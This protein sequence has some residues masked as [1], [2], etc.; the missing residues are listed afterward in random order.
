MG[1]P[2]LIEL[3]RS[4]SRDHLDELGRAVLAI[5]RGEGLGAIDAAFRA[6]H[7]LKGMSAAMD[8][9]VVAELAHGLEHT[10]ESLRAG[11]VRADP[12][13]VDT[14][15]RAVDE[16]ERV[17]EAA[18]SGLAERSG[19]DGGDESFPAGE[20]KP[21]VP[22]GASPPGRVVRIPEARIDGLLERTGDLLVARE[23]IIARARASRDER[24]R[25]LAQEFA[26]SIEELRDDALRLRLAPIG[27]I[28]DRIARVVRDTARALDKRVRLHLA[29]VDVEID[30]A[31]LGDVQDLLTHLLRNA[32]DHGIETIAGREAAGKPAEG[33]VRVTVTQQRDSV[34]L[35][36]EDDGRGIDRELV[37][38]RAIAAGIWRSTPGVPIGDEDLLRLLVHPGFTTAH[39]VTEV[40]GRGVG[41]DHVATRSREVGGDLRIASRP[42]RGSRFTLVL[43]R[44]LSQ[45]KVLLAGS[46]GQI[47]G[48]PAGALR[49]IEDEGQLAPGVPEAQDGERERP[50]IEVVDLGG[51]L[52]TA[53]GETPGNPAFLVV[54]GDA[55]RR[56]KLRVDT[57]IGLQEVVVRRFARPRGMSEAFGGATILADGTPCL[58]IEPLRL[59]RDRPAGSAGE[60]TKLT[61]TRI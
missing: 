5:E 61:G 30:R 50:S 9:S 3:Y 4:E 47:V 18:C 14:I 23:R 26:R 41:L 56:I 22:P 38:R 20:S 35:R 57:L 54:L 46:C 29:G 15:L 40:S 34:I 13:V 17:V 45:T 21:M 32:V 37:T 28:A 43:P 11:A 59:L 2:S 42:G 55:E 27:D 39:E 51:L 10:L 8:R 33:H 12:E 7:T 52:G 60:W 19:A 48:I 44:T 24:M 16:L 1:E 49:R 58:I 25:E 53:G 6:A 31:L 36:V